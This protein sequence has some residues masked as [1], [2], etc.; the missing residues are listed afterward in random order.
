VRERIAV[1]EEQWKVALDERPAQRWGLPGEGH[2][3]FQL[4]SYAFLHAGWL[5]LFGNL[6][7]LYLA[8]PALE[9]R[10][11]RPLFFVFYIAAAAFAGLGWAATLD[12][13][14]PCIG[15]SGAVAGAM[16]A[17]LMRWW[18]VRIRFFYFFWL[19]IRPLVGTFEAP[20]YLMLPLWFLAQ[21]VA[22]VGSSSASSGV[23][24]WAHVWGFVFGVG[25]AWV[26]HFV[27]I[28]ERIRPKLEAAAGVTEN[29]ALGDAAEALERGN[30]R[31]A[32]QILD[33][34]LRADPV[35]RDALEMAWDLAVRT[36]AASTA[37][38]TVLRLIGEE[39]R[40]EEVE[41]ATRHFSE[42]R[43]TVPD[44]RVPA[45]LQV[46]IVEAFCAVAHYT[47]ALEETERLLAG[48]IAPALALRLARAVSESHP[49]LAGRVARHGLEQGEEALAPE[50]RSAL[51]DFVAEVRSGPAAVGGEAMDLEV[52]QGKLEQIAPDRLVFDLAGRGRVSLPLGRVHGLV[53]V[54]V[55]GR[56]FVDLLLDPPDPARTRARVARVEL[57]QS[58]V[59]LLGLPGPEAVAVALADRV[60][61]LHPPWVA[62]ADGPAH[63]AVLANAARGA[64]LG[65]GSVQ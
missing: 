22:A 8:G 42:L 27:G 19:I 60:G 29:R 17:F 31:Q 1:L 3:T 47:P 6:L 4:V 32:Q 24:F 16:G 26:V 10:W 15:A 37:V 41:L 57:D 5:H 56:K 7:I 21:L 2:R 62:C 33:R 64:L 52:T 39:L 30:L 46:R 48:P 59:A 58:Q 14:L 43:R 35:D 34:S 25:F 18:R 50:I 20:A 44:A 12:S 55:A 61:R 54:D 13:T 38:S 49:L 28:E 36:G 65:G 11:G 53:A 51:T 23:A 63:A 40:A 9:D 45:S